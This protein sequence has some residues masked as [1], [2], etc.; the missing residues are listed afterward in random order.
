MGEDADKNLVLDSE[1]AWYAWFLVTEA[2]CG[3]K[4]SF[5][6]SIVASVTSE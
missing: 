3:L 1:G 4:N 6:L 5:F 2:D